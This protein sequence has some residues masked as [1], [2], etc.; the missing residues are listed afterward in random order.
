MTLMARLKNVCLIAV[1]ILLCVPWNSAAADDEIKVDSY[2]IRDLKWQQNSDSW[3]SEIYGD[4]VPAY[5]MYEL[6][7]PHRLIIDIAN[8]NFVGSIN[9]PM[10]VD[11]GP[12]TLIKGVVLIDQNPIVA[13]I[14]FLLADDRPYSV[15]SSGNDILVQFENDTRSPA[16]SQSKGTERLVK[17]I[18][19]DWSGS[20][21]KVQLLAD[22]P[23]QK[24]QSTELAKEKDHPARLIVDL[25][26]IATPGHAIPTN[27]ASPI[28]LVRSENYK[29]GTRV[30]LDSATDDLFRYSI[31]VQKDGLLI[32][33]E[34]AADATPLIAE[35][36]GLSAA[37]IA[38]STPALSS[39]AAKTASTAASS[40]GAEKKPSAAVTKVSKSAAKDRN[41]DFAFA[42]YTEQRISVDFYKIDLHN[43]FRLIGEISG[44][45]IVVDEKV[46]GSLTLALND[47]PWDFVLDV[48]LNLKDLAKEERFNTVVISQKSD[49]FTWPQ[50]AEETLA[51]KKEA[52]SVTKRMEV[53]KEKL[54][55]RKFIRQAKN[56][57]DS[58]NYEG[59]VTFYEKAFQSWPENGDL[60]KRITYLSLVKLGLN[61]KA[62]HYGQIASNL[63][64]QDADVALQTALS[65]A[66]MEMVKEAKSYFE[67][68]V[69]GER[70]SR[71]ALA[72]Y[73][74]FSEQN[75]S[76]EMALSLLER[77]E[78][79][80]GTSFE[81]MVSKA[82][83]YDNMG[84]A[85]N[86]SKEYQA[87]LL[88][89]YK[90]P[91]DLEKYIKERLHK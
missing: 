21:T 52:I 10:K 23:I 58:G 35:I 28:S 79:I 81:T 25:P 33:V 65:L 54:E 87:I 32:N 26:G 78:R 9:F 82:R 17:D 85:E 39:A 68:A 44:R 1:L 61:A 5:T 20:M 6:F 89:G 18:N 43:V 84:D 49:S 2:Q 63:L 19:I 42:G 13:R 41:T 27:D 31:V 45:N 11:K 83:I 47:V 67:F 34:P 22:G 38:Q 62:A 66:N 60:A 30:I 57:E 3:L 86:A 37:E 80:Y 55:A 72:S 59:A 51:I 53:P 73:A 76:N 91:A 75:R 46:N 74:A 71:Q 48:I 7:S 24:Y 50:R 88:S 69:S 12:V 14:E 90:V 8:G 4:R 15:T 36:T 70:P 16:A 64:P 29:D 56:L 77:F 40:Q